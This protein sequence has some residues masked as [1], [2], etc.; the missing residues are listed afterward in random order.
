LAALD[1]AGAKTTAS[2]LT[3]RAAQAAAAPWFP[4][5]AVTMP[6]APCSP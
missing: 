6:A 1:A 3:C 2:S 5:D 4:V